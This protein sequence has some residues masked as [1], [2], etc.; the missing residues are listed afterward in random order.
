MIAFDKRSGKQRWASEY[1][2]PAGHTG[3]LVPII[4]DGVPCVAVLTLR[5]LLVLRLDAGHEGKTFTTFPWLSA[6]A[7]NVLTP[8]V[9]GDCVLISSWHTHKSLCK[10]KITLGGAK[11]LWEKPYA[12]FIGTPVIDRDRIYM[13][14]DSVLCLDWAT[15]RLLWEGGSFDYGGAVILTADNRLIVWSNRGRLTLV[16]SA[17]E[18]P[19]QFKQ[20]ARIPRI[21]DGENAWPHPAFA[22]GLLLCKSRQGTIKCFGSGDR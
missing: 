2:G 12:S 18:S 9:K 7:N 5:H 22:D 8:A 14:G 15:G 16:A 19:A 4:V 11:K 3:G 6:W 20:L 21:F 17:A 1:R 10:L 13:A